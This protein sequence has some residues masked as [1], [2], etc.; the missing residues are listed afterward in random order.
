M[1][2]DLLWSASRASVSSLGERG[3]SRFD[4]RSWLPDFEQSCL[5]PNSICA[6]SY[7]QPLALTS[8]A[9]TLSFFVLRVLPD[10][11]SFSDSLAPLDSGKDGLRFDYTFKL[12][13]SVTNRGLGSHLSSSASPTAT[14]SSWLPLRFVEESLSLTLH[15]ALWQ[16]GVDYSDI[17]GECCAELYK[18]RR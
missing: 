8:L 2:R 7:L 13:S 6:C 12:A 5:K 10:S 16:D 1:N 3:R 11:S 14:F 17:T 4:P 18:S 15:G 9:P